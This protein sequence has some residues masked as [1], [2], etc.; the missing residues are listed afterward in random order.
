MPAEL[1]ILGFETGGD[2]VKFRAAWRAVVTALT[3]R[4]NISSPG[5]DWSRTPRS[6]P[7]KANL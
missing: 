7:E 5:S 3:G 1:L 6:R 4:K 2:A